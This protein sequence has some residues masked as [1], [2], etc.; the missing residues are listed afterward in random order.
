MGFHKRYI[1]K[2]VII[3]AFKENGA[4]RVSDL[5]IKSDAI[6]TEPNSPICKYITK[7]MHLNETLEYKHHLINVYMMQLLEGLYPHK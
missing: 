7:I 6:T 5:Y 2:Q 1:S 4:E 3:S